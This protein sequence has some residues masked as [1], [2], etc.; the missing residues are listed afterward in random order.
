MGC[1]C[2]RVGVLFLESFVSH[3]PCHFILLNLFPLTFYTN[4]W[5]VISSACGKHFFPP[6]RLSLLSW[7]VLFLLSWHCSNIT[8]TLAYNID[9]QL[10]WLKTDFVKS[11]G[12]PYKNICEPIP[13]PHVYIPWGYKDASNIHCAFKWLT[14]QVGSYTYIN[15]STKCKMTGSSKSKDEVL[16]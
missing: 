1:P 9:S 8:A 7:S 3:Y 5:N 11:F 15:C 4:P 12:Q 13:S 16:W 14:V 6:L 10:K 2:K